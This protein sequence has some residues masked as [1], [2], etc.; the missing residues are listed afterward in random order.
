MHAV[1]APPVHFFARVIALARLVLGPGMNL[2]APPNLS[3]E[4]F[5]TLLDSGI[6]DWGGISP[7]TAD[8]I[9]PE[10]PWPQVDA[11]RALGERKGFTLR[12]RLP[13]Y[14]EFAAREEFFSPR[15][16]KVVQGKLAA[17]PS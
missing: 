13:V 11:L 8:F 17:L 14:D 5:E 1:P 10:K 12:P 15:I 4:H 2:Q 6:N 7:L 9:N 16:W 3:P